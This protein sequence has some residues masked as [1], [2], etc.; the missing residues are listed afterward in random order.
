G[1]S[2]FPMR[3]PIE[4]PDDLGLIPE[5]RFAELLLALP[6]DWPLAPE[7]FN[8]EAN[9]WPLRW[10]KKLARLAHRMDGWLGLGHTVP[11]GD[12]PRPL[13]PNVRV[14]WWL[15]HEPVLLPQEV[16]ALR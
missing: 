7:A 10:L 8:D 1:M 4:N 5:V 16:Q 12:P 15:V 14:A 2:E 11:N 13:G 9:Y 3:V 6:P